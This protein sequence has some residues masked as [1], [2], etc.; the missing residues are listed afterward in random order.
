ME[1]VGDNHQRL[2]LSWSSGKDSCWALHQLL[3]DSG[4]R[5]VGLLTTFNSHFQRS[6]IHGVRMELLRLQAKAIGLPLIEV[7]LPWP[8]DNRQYEHLM[9]DALASARRQLQIQTVA[10]GDLYLE[11]IRLYRER[12]MADT[13]LALDFPLWQL[14]TGLLAQQ[15]LDGGLRAKVTCIDP[16]FVPR[17]LAGSEYDRGFLRALPETVDPCGENGEFHTFVYDAPMFAAPLSIS[18]GETV[19][20]DGFVYTD[21]L[22]EE[23]LCG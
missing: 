4:V 22:S 16:K 3:Q 12:Q 13:G 11:D 21:F 6:A 8:C 23:D 20:R 1:L 15:M 17:E 5:V 18:A 14:P 9:A 2:L 7:G 10:F 19:Q